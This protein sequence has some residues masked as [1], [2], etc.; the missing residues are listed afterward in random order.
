MPE[1]APSRSIG[2]CLVLFVVQLFS[3]FRCY[4]F[5]TAERV[6][7][8]NCVV[9]RKVFSTVWG[10]SQWFS[11]QQGVLYHVFQ[12][13]SSIHGF[14]HWAFIILLRILLAIVRPHF[15]CIKK[16]RGFPP[17]FGGP[18]SFDQPQINVAANSCLYNMQTRA[19][20][21]ELF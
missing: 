11:S 14:E 10:I 12:G 16:W 7:H 6:P 21:Q 13:L 20:M 17:P 15:L 2:S 18:G 1:S 9:L 8:K 4:Q 3:E 5:F 19:E